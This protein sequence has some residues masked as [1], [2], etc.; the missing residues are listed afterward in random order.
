MT[1]IETKTT[2]LTGA[3]IFLEGLKKEGVDKIFG[4]PGGVILSIYEALYNQS[5]ITH[6]RSCTGDIWSRCNK[7]NNRHCK[8]IL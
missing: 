3:E 1:E 8:C 4:Y 5:D 7:C 2:K 6:C